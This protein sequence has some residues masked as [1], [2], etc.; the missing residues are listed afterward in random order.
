M[1]IL[2][3]TG[4]RIGPLILWTYQNVHL[5]NGPGLVGMVSY[6]FSLTK[7][8]ILMSCC[9]FLYRFI[10]DV[11]QGNNELNSFIT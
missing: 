1:V 5:Y 11:I 10:V 2:E 8:A 9:M 7:S 6:D 3:L 4:H